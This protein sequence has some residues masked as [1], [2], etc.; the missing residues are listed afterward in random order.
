MRRILLSTAKILISGALL[1]LALR[2]VDLSEL[3]SRLT[4]TSLLWIAMAIA[5]TF[6]QIFVGVVR[7]REISA[8]CGAPLE[9]G[10]AMRYNVIGA[11]FNQTLPSAI[12][13]DAVRLWLVARAGAGWRA[14]TYSIFVDRAIGLVALAIVVVASLPWSYELITDPHGR[15]ALLL[16]DLAALAGGVGFLIFGALKWSWLKTWWATHHIH[17]CAV[18]ANRVI[19]NAKRGP[20]VAILSLLVH[21]LAVVIAWCVVQSIAAPVN[22]GQTFLLIPPIM[23]I[24]LMP[25]SIAGWGV[26]EATMGLAFGFAGLSANEGVN[27]S[28]LFGAVLF[29]VGAI[30]G[31]VWILSAE[32]A[33][34]GSAPLGVPE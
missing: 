10:R 20:I 2:K 8:E 28:L 31:L 19:F 21:V 25:I 1:Y 22:F 17:A 13:G 26:R 11:F 30:G 3:F 23:L 9:L 15:S 6:L 4:A 12:G 16:V 7:W 27:V 5:V 14:A 18:I 34:K 33:A 24:T 29:I 32:K